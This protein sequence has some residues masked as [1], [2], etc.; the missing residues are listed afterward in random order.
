MTS[1]EF[2]EVP[3]VYGNEETDQNVQLSESAVFGASVLIDLCCQLYRA[4]VDQ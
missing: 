3:L 1:I 2:D 4:G